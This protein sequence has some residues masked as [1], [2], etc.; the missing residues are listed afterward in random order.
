MFSC[1]DR[2]L[3]PAEIIAIIMQMDEKK[4]LDVKL[5]CFSL[6]P[7]DVE[8]IE[9]SFLGLAGKIVVY[10]AVFLLA[11]LTSYLQI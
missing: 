9:K 10:L 8:S 5:A 1:C 6:V 3:F 2:L 7:A 11:P 4:Y